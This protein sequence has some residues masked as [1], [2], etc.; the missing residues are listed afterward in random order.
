ML[1][2]DV[3]EHALCAKAS[4]AAYVDCLQ[5]VCSVLQAFVLKRAIVLLGSPVKWIQDRVVHDSE[6]TVWPEHIVF[7]LN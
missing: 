3:L 2:V 5:I 6:E 4:S 7:L 1:C